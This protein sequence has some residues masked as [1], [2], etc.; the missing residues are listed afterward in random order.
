[1]A[2]PQAVGGFS[3]NKNKVRPRLVA[4]VAGLDKCGKT[5]LALSSPGPIAYANF[6]TGLEGVLEKFQRTGKV[7]YSNDYRVKVPAG[8]STTQTAEIANKVWEGLKEDVRAAIKSPLIRTIVGDTESEMWELCRLARFGKLTQVMPHHYGPVNTEYRN[9]WNEIYDSDKNLILLGRMKDEWEN[10]VVN[11]KEVG[12]KTGRLERIGFKEI[13]YMVQLN[14]IAKYDPT[15]P[16]GDRFSLE[17]TNCRQNSDLAG[18]VLP[19]SLISFTQLA[20]LVYPDSTDAD[21]ADNKA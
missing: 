12:K 9:F 6:D 17:I 5:H 18:M 1:M 13:Q 8:A 20:Q 15:A 10:T 16:A 7:V 14:A 19:Q 21:W 11:G 3:L 4:S 2:A